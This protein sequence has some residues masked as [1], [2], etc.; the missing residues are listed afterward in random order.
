[1][2]FLWLNKRGTRIIGSSLLAAIILVL[3]I[4][5]LPTLGT[6]FGAETSFGQ[7]GVGG[8]ASIVLGRSPYN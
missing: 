2:S 7:T 1:M 6:G 5:V 3:I 4:L 8:G